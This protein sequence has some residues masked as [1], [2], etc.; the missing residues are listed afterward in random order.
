MLLKSEHLKIFFV[1]ILMRSVSVMAVYTVCV[2]MMSLC[3]PVLM[4]LSVCV[5]NCQLIIRLTE[6]S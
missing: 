6:E 1:I 2:L 4:S 5:S 3:W